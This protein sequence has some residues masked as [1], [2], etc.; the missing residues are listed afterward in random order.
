MGEDWRAGVVAICVVCGGGS[1]VSYTMHVK[2][3]GRGG[4]EK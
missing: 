3:G 2:E 4:I 1:G